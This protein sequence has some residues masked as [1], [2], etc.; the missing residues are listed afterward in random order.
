[1]WQA[2]VD[3]IGDQLAARRDVDGVADQAADSSAGHGFDHVTAGHLTGDEAGRE[4]QGAR[5]DGFHAG[6]GT[7]LGQLG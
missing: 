5:H 6:L 3:F 7:G 1:L 2:E 4:L